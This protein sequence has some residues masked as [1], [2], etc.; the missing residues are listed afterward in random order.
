MF[1]PLC[2]IIGTWI[3]RQ[4]FRLNCSIYRTPFGFHRSGPKLLEKSDPSSSVFPSSSVLCWSGFRRW[5]MILY[6]PID[7]ALDGS[8]FFIHYIEFQNC[9]L[10]GYI[11]NFFIA[12]RWPR[13][14]GGNRNFSFVC[15]FVHTEKR[16]DNP[17]MP[18]SLCQVDWVFF[19]LPMEW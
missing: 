18:L 10:N 13:I 3:S 19:L 5:M 4:P 12:V 14:W 8:Q 17:E 7:P 16:V 6:V 1:K 2:Y 11:K 15:S 9:K